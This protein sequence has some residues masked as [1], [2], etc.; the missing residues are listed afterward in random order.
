MISSFGFNK[1]LLNLG[2]FINNDNFSKYQNEDFQIKKLII[3]VLRNN[4]L[5]PHSK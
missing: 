3:F 1:R 2:I 4:N 5:L